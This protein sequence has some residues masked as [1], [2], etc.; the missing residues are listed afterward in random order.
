MTLGAEGADR[1]AGDQ[2]IPDADRG[3]AER[4][5]TAT[6]MPDRVNERAGDLQVPAFN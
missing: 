4:L 6:H 1:A 2:H 5:L 3:E